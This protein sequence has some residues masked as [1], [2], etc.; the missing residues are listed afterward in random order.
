MAPT[1]ASIPTQSTPNLASATGMQESPTWYTHAKQYWDNIDSNIEGMLG[2]FGSLTTIDARTNKEFIREYVQDGC[3]KTARCC[4]CGAGIGRVTSSFLIHCFQNVDLVEQTEKF[5]D[6]AKIDFDSL[7]YGSRVSFIPLG[8][9]NF[10]PK[11]PF[12]N[13][14]R[15]L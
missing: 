4:D 5:L 3:L 14:E 8:L 12:H 6:Q 9:Q 10:Y 7:G 11:V 1:T 13:P 2:G 15:I